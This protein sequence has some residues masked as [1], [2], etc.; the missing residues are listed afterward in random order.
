MDPL[1][2]KL[3]QPREA[4]EKLRSMGGI[5]SSSPQ[6]AQT[7]QKFQAGGPIRASELQIPSVRSA[8]QQGGMS[9]PSYQMLSRQQRAGLGYPVSEI[10]GQLAF[11][12]FGVGLGRVDPAARFSPSGFRV[13]SVEERAAAQD[14][15][16]NLD[17]QVRSLAE[18]NR[19]EGRRG[20]FEALLDT[21]GR[22]RAEDDRR[23]EEA[24]VAPMATV[25][26]IEAE[27]LRQAGVPEPGSLDMAGGRPPRRG[28]ARPAGE[29]E[30]PLSD[31]DAAATLSD[32]DAAATQPDVPTLDPEQ[33]ETFETTYEQMLKRLEGV[34]GKKDVDTRKKAM[35]NLAMIG[36]AIASGQS[37]N[38]LTNIAQGALSGMQAIR[39]EE[40]SREEQERAVRMAALKAAL[41]AESSVAA[42]QARAAE[43]QLDRENRLAVA[44]L[45]SSSAGNRN[46]RAIEDFV[47]NTYNTALAAAI[48][49]TP[50]D[51]LT[52]GESPEAYAARKAEAARE[53]MVTQFPQSYG[54][55]A[56]GID[57]LTDEE[58][59]LLGEE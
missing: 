32:S 37:P 36:L 21:T 18:E 27:L 54:V 9:F 52:P 28:G 31:G 58:R 1:S 13:P 33:P 35:A 34:M 48:S 5:M 16:G 50:P 56:G 17:E 3:F 41:D 7:V 30:D 46:F 45:R 20:P 43:G 11:D 39:A 19:A 51:D 49:V 4:R 57:D 29:G 26:D 42:G 15:Q 14:P 47:Q 44:G 23:A 8:I 24:G 22:R 38:A 6:L 25:G 2:R 12:R 53:Y 55:P 10:G 40:A 59:R